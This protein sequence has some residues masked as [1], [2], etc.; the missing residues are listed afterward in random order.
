MQKDDETFFI[1][2]VVTNDLPDFQQR[3][4]HIRREEEIHTLFRGQKVNWIK[5]HNKDKKKTTFSFAKYFLY[6]VN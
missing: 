3:Y 4:F 6:S 2:S 5:T 1:V